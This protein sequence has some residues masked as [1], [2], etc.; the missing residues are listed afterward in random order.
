MHAIEYHY[1]AESRHSLKEKLVTAVANGNELAAE[2]LRMLLRTHTPE[3][4]LASR[5]SW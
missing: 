1:Q 3:R 5:F 4:Q 2:E